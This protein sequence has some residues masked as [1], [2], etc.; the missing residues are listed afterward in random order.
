VP[1]L[2]HPPALPAQGTPAGPVLVSA[3][4][5][6]TRGAGRYIPLS[7]LPGDR[8]SLLAGAQ[9]LNAP[10]DVIQQLSTLPADRTY[11]TV[12]EIWAALGHHNEDVT[13]RS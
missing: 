2:V 4:R 12:N 9:E 8:E 3:A 5:A 7:R 6:V 10:D 1:D 11:Q 13:R